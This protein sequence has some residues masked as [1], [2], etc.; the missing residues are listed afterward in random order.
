MG[1]KC[2]GCKHEGKS[3]SMCLGCVYYPKQ[4]DRFEPAEP[5]VLSA[6]QWFN[7]HKGV[8]YLPDEETKHLVL[9][10]SGAAFRDGHNNGRLE[11]DLELRGLVD[12]VDLL[13]YEGAIDLQKHGE[14]LEAIRETARNLKPI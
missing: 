14:I 13:N 10:W 1:N 4:V 8:K 2:D 6:D 5:V 12:V 7:N 11:R 9:C 3:I